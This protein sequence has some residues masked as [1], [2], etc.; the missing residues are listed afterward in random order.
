MRYNISKLFVFGLVMIMLAS[1]SVVSAQQTTQDIEG[2][3]RDNSYDTVDNAEVRFTSQNNGMEYYGNTDND[4][5][6]EIHNIPDGN[7]D[8]NINA[9]GYD[10]LHQT[11]YV[12]GGNTYF[13]FTLSSQNGG[14]DGDGGDGEDFDP[15]GQATEE[16]E[17]IIMYLIMATVLFYTLLIIITIM[18]I[19]IF[20]RL[21]KIKRSTAELKDTVKDLN[22]KTM[23]SQPQYQQPVQQP[24]P[25]Q[26]QQPPPEQPPEY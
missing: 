3:V 19:A 11:T 7:Y 20:V 24:A 22:N 23:S 10:E 12:D 5:E 4:G 18:T 15:F 17:E 13:D 14:D 9:G 1:L 2:R 25:E 21:G 8:V 26:Y 16:F 6:F